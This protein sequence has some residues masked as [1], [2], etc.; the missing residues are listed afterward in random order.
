VVPGT[1]DDADVS[2]PDHQVAGLRML[3]SE[4]VVGA[5]IKVGRVRVGIGE[6][7]PVIDRVDQ[8]RAVDARSTPQVAVEG[9]VNDRRPFAR[10]EQCGACRCLG[11][12]GNSSWHISVLC[13]C[14]GAGHGKSQQSQQR[15]FSM[16][17]DNPSIVS[18]WARGGHITAVL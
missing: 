11:S 2:G 10:G 18:G 14:R 4:K 8:V 7:G 16:R 17:V 5:A 6:S 1:D 12:S 13:R 15:G 9:G 3:D